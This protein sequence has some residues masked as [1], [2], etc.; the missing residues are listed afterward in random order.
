MIKILGLLTLGFMLATM[1]AG[2]IKVKIKYHMIL[3]ALAVI[4]GIAHI[5]LIVIK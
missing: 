1:A 3:G 2:M 5:A 4:F